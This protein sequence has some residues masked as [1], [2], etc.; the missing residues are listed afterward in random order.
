[1]QH[2]K[3]L[4]ELKILFCIFVLFVIQCYAYFPSTRALASYLVFCISIR[5]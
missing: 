3:K 4:L 1:M 2:E 5:I